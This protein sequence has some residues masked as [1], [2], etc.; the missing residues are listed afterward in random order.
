MPWGSCCRGRCLLGLSAIAVA[1]C[2]FIALVPL[3]GAAPTPEG[4]PGW[5]R[6]VGRR[7][8]GIFRHRQHD[9]HV[10]NDP[11]QPTQAT[12]GPGGLSAVGGTGFG[13]S[14]RQ[15]SFG[16][17]W[18]SGRTDAHFPGKSHSSSDRHQGSADAAK[19]VW[20]SLALPHFRSSKVQDVLERLHMDAVAHLSDSYHLQELVRSYM[21]VLDE[22]GKLLLPEM[23]ET[24][25]AFIDGLTAI[26]LDVDV[27]SKRLLYLSGIPIVASKGS[28]S[29]DVELR[30]TKAL[31]TLGVFY[32]L[33]GRLNQLSSLVGESSKVI[34]KELKKRHAF[35]SQLAKILMPFMRLTRYSLDSLDY[36]ADYYRELHSAI[37][38]S[39]VYP[40]L[41]TSTYS[42]LHM[43]LQAVGQFF[44]TCLHARKIGASLQHDISELRGST[45]SSSWG[46][47][48]V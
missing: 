48:S 44:A 18:R 17:D 1:V 3:A 31:H 35:T 20:Q 8:E 15:A 4:E 40:L 9:R 16:T 26:V 21:T 43:S 10:S 2:A 6:R 41:V 5:L 32:V 13:H 14:Q 37:I 33:Q 38:G 45:G 36:L 22:A 11:S 42:R 30:K 25:R 39:T 34:C 23:E 29:S 46:P 28:E 12:R 7:V 47:P 19:T 27:C 24:I